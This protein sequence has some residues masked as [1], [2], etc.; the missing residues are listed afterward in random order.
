M[1]VSQGDQG[2]SDLLC[3]C[4]W[5][6]T[7]VTCTAAANLPKV[8]ASAWGELQL[9]GLIAGVQLLSPCNSHMTVQTCARWLHTFKQRTITR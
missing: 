7:R 3:T 5:S 2:N 9:L 4:A 1:E 8:R 6:L